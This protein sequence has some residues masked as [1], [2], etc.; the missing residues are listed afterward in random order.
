MVTTTNNG[1]NRSRYS[2]FQLFSKGLTQE[3]WPEL[4]SQPDMKSSYEVVIIGGGLHGLA[5]AYYLAKNHGITDIAVIDKG[6]IGGG[7]S[8]RN[9]SILRSNYLTPEGVRFYD[10]SL[11]LYEDLSNELNFNLMFVQMGHMSLAHDD[12]GVRTMRWRA[13]VNKAQGVDS[14][15]IGPD[16][17]KE[18]VPY[19]DVSENTRYPILGALYHP[20]GGTIRHDAVVWA[21]ARAAHE[22]GVHIIQHTEVTGIDV[23]NSKVTGVQTSQGNIATGTAVN[24]TAG[25]ASLISDMAG[26]RMP[27]TTS[28]LQAAV[29]EPVKPFLGTVVVSGTLHVYVSQTD[30]GELVFGAS[31]D[32]F[33]SYSMRGTLEFVEGLATNVLSLMPSLSK[34]RL[35]RQWGGLC[36]MTPDY[37]PIMGETEVDG[38]YVDVGW[39]TYGFKAGPVSGEAMAE[40][41]AT[42]K[43]PE[44]IQGFGLDRF[45][46]GR[47]VGEKGAA[48]VGH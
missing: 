48:A 33:T 6:Y 40:T 26:V 13:E 10:R 32:P 22:M 14:E 37:S 31:V 27:V 9:T 30:R 38:F 25:W 47:L 5:T 44:I 2:A 35:L 23:D 39:G 18:L 17:I 43:R 24:C 21:Y 28:P 11:K 12:G 45:S 42:G 41:I 8:G 1:N 20:P 7:G 36:D 34:M 15:V 29:T 3:S 19:L 46:S 16:E 4:W